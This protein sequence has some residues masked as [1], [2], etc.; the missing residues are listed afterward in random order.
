MMVGLLT[1][2]SL[3]EIEAVMSATTKSS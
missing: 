1:D 3:P 2:F